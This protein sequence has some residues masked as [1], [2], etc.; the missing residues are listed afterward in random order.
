M[1]IF[2]EKTIL[3]TG[4]CGTV[5]VE[6]VRQIVSGGWGKPKNILAV[7]NNES[8][9]FF[10]QLEYRDIPSVY[11]RVADITDPDICKKIGAGVDVT[12][13]CAALKHVLMC[14]NSPD[15]AIKTNIIGV[16]NIIDSAVYN[17]MQKVI[18]TSSDKAVNPTNLMGATK[19]AGERLIL[20]A[21]ERFQTE[22]PTFTATRFGNILGSSGSVLQVFRRQIETGR[23]LTLTNPEMTRFIMTVEQAVRLVISSAGY[24]IGGEIFVTK[25][26]ALRIVDLAQSVMEIYSARLSRELDSF[27]MKEI[28]ADPSEKVFE[29]LMS[30]TE[31]RNAVELGDFFVLLRDHKTDSNLKASYGDCVKRLSANPYNSSSQEPLTVDKIKDLLV[32][33]RLV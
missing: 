19:L 3:I 28:G 4:C 6:L 17:R 11:F 1:S 10:Q 30:V 16:Q 21:G 8:A 33:N 7:D 5:G 29:E 13:H 2:E 9:L 15:Q 25:M 18:L 23:A 12:F 20:A 22:G 24:A 31:A 32:T 26:P 27:K 14:E